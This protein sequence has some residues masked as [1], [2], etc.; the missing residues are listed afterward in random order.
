MNVLL[1]LAGK[2]LPYSLISALTDN[3]PIQPITMTAAF[4][5][6]STAVLPS[7]EP[8]ICAGAMRRYLAMVPG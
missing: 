3:E 5:T 7:S 4:V 1:R 8:S 2:R 6:L